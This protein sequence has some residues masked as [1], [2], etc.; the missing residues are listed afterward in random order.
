[1]T[2][3]SSLPT[4][5]DPVDRDVMRDLV[6]RALAED[7]GA[8][9]LTSA[10]TI[11]AGAV[12]G[13]A[14]LA[15][16][17]CVVAGLDV[18]REVFAQVDPAIVFEP[19]SADGD[20]CPA[21]TVL[22]RLTGPAA[23]IL[24]AER[25]ALNFLQHLSGIATR[26]RAFVDA[27]GG[28][29]GIL[30]TRKTIPTLRALA[31][32]A[33]RCGGGVNHRAG[34]FDAVLVKDNHIALSG[35][36]AEAVRKARAAAPGRTVEVEAQDLQQVD[37]AI[38]A[39][40]DIIMLDNLPVGVMREAIA[41]IAKRAKVEISGGVTLDR[42]PELATLGADYI[43]VG[44]LTHSAPAAD[45]CLEVGPPEPSAK[46]EDPASTGLVCFDH[47]TSTNDVALE[48]AEQGAPDG[49]AVL[50]DQ[51]RAGRGR[52][53]R[54]WFSPPG[55]GLYLSIVARPCDWVGGLALITLAAGVAAARGV[56][57]ASALPVE[58]KWPN[59]LVV[60][61]PW[62]KIGGVLC[63]AVAGARGPDAVVVGIGINLQ[64]A[65]YPPEIA[66]RASSL[67]VELGRPVDRSHL[68]EAIREELKAILARMRA[69]DA[70]WLLDAWRQLGAA[71]LAGAP[72]RWQ[73]QRGWRQGIARDIDPD[74]AL[75]V[76]VDGRRERVVAGEVVWDRVPS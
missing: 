24:T 13:A 32:Y 60:G 59:D 8:G 47:V 36:V 38:A 51:Q 68:V 67:E 45:V 48:M 56:T 62:R 17:D 2:S 76:H 27:A 1:M 19:E 26:T 22:A 21:G 4:L 44:A 20:T 14:L 35:G 34:L 52:R 5:P 70:A 57:S 69:G 18:V 49:T 16:A 53:G 43:S 11:P 29:V 40:A 3:R 31:K 12:A 66:D 41:R 9:D 61:R 55:A 30:D 39:G 42:M 37:E 72:V 33:V 10:A 23:A 15:R 7:V 58:L 50:A 63:E 64:P 6:R 25:T 75:V 54:T 71:G 73:D 65:A 28:R 46:T 74:G